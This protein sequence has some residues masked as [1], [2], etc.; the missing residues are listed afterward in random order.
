MTR[1][2]SDALG[3]VHDYLRT[4]VQDDASPK[5]ARARLRLLE[6]RHPDTSME[7]VWQREA[8]DDSVHYDVLLRQ[9]GAG[10]TS[11]SY[12]ADRVQPWPLRSAQRWSD[13]DLFRVN[14]TRMP[15]SQAVACLD[16]IWDEAPVIDRLVNACLI[17]EELD[18]EPIELTDAEVQRALDGFRRAKRLYSVQDTLLWLERRGITHAELEAL[19]T[20]EALVAKLR[21]R[22]TNG[23]VEAYFEAHRADFDAAHIAR[24]SFASEADARAARDLIDSAELDFYALAQRQFASGVAAVTFDVVQRR[25]R[26]AALGEPVLAA[27]PGDIVGPLEDGDAHILAQVITHTPAQL[28]P[29]TYAIIERLLFERWLAER[30]ANADIEWYWWNAAHTRAFKPAPAA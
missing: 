12:C 17:Q 13:Q 18:T 25:S 2:I 15:V 26:A 11:L 24:V 19:V 3:E 29:R 9:D 7:L 20:D 6:R 8:F 23:R 16:F 21:Q 1:I 22:V 28:D 27:Q 4:L 14:N 5:E 10:T 30:R